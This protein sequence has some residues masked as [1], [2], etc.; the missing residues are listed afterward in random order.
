MCNFVQKMRFLSAVSTPER[1]GERPD[2]CCA[3]RE[4]M[5]NLVFLL[6]RRASWYWI[7]SEIPV[8]KKFFFTPFLSPLVRSLVIFRSEI[9]RFR[10][11]LTQSLNTV[12]SFPCDAR[13]F[14]LTP[15]VYS[16]IFTAP[17]SK[18]GSV[19]SRIWPKKKVSKLALLIVCYPIMWNNSIWW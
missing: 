10:Y 12:T 19:I 14:L 8:L 15:T 7:C 3:Q 17:G 1:A 13:W 6:C 4:A 9:V 16:L 18:K 11:F 2:F 5:A